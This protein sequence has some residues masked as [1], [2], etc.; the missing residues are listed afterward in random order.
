[1]TLLEHP[2]VKEYFSCVLDPECKDPSSH[3]AFNVIG[4]MEESIK[5]GELYLR[6]DFAGIADPMIGEND[7][8]V[9]ERESG[10]WKSEGHNSEWIE[11]YKSKF[12]FH[13]LALRIP[14]RFQ[15]QKCN[16]H[17]HDFESIGHAPGCEESCNKKDIAPEAEAG[18]P[19]I[20]SQFLKAAEECG[21]FVKNI[22]LEQVRKLK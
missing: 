20:E 15:N 9:S 19:E 1:M 10:N 21:N 6:I 12:L 2:L 8:S 5:R 13:P 4:A 11:N 22:F 14:D 16:C 7:F 17:C 3:R 18:R